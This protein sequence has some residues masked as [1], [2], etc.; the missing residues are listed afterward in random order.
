MSLSITTIN[1]IL[2][3]S[4]Q[5]WNQ[6][7]GTHYPFLRHEF[8][9]ALESSGCTTARTGWQPQH[10]CIY[11]NEQL[12]A[13]MPMYQKTNSNGEYVFDWDWANAYARYQ[14]E[15]YPKLV[16]AIPF[17]PCY[18]P[19]IACTIALEQVLPDII[20]YI[21]ALCDKYD[22]SSW[23]GLFPTPEQHTAFAFQGLLSRIGI[24]YHWQNNNYKS[25]DQYLDTFTSRKRKS[26]KRERRTVEAQN[27]TIE[28]IEGCDI[29]DELLTHFYYCYQL[30]YL[31][32]GRQGYLN[33]HFFKQLLADIPKHIVLFAAKYEGNIVACAWC[34]KNTDPQNSVL[35]GR[36]W[37]CL[38]NF[39]SL[40]FETC[41]YRG[42]EY[43]IEHNIDRF[44]PGA[45]GEHKIKRGF[46]PITTY[47]SHYIADQ[48]FEIAIAD[49][50]D[51]ETAAIN[52]H[53]LHLTE[54]LPFKQKT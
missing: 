16:T 44:D 2:Q 54:Q 7:C 26:I 24:Q 28:C 19:R 9:A 42:L 13:I 25:F 23:H 18:G 43:C 11:Q 17:S 39:D 10:L 6:V 12:V 31:K 29:N 37:G 46:K 1:S 27:V 40:H 45:Q 53:K 4:P 14:I 49:F 21:K 30:T 52:E 8:L 22:F 50:L 38:D 47:S 51:R 15:Y 48:Q 36:Y 41:Y 33:E 20:Q 5:S 34:F 35:Y 3:I 32:R